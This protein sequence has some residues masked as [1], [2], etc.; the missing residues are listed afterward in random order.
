MKAFVTPGTSVK[1]IVKIIFLTIYVLVIIYPLLFVFMSSIKTN[2]EVF[3]RP[4]ALP[5]TWNFSIY[6]ELWI[7]HQ[8]G[9]YFANSIY[10]AFFTVVI[11]VLI[12]AMAAYA[13]VRMKWRLKGFV[14]MLI[15]FGLMVPIHSEVVP[16]YIIVNKLGL[17][18]PRFSL[19]GIYIAFS[20]P[21]TVFILSGFIRGIPRAMEESAVIEGSG[22]IGA[23]FRIILPLMKPA[24]A[25]VVI[26]NF[27]TVWNDFFA[28]LIFIGRE[29]QKTIQL[30]V[31][32][33]QGTFSTD[34]STLLAGIII[35]IIPSVI[36]YALVQDKIIEGITAGAVKG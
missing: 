36:V 31:T 15:L 25:T 13:L 2:A 16:L 21:I 12:S 5:E 19:L 33:F 28:A 4:F 6:P 20:L 26:F 14:F 22:I 10:Y 1:N 8:L 35:V 29:S 11:T 18:N 32:K 7:E 34:Y 23:F 24:L 30:G 3:A 27:L 9:M 17:R